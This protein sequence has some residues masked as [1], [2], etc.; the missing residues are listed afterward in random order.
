MTVEEEEGQ[1]PAAADVSRPRKRWRDTSGALRLTILVIVLF[2]TDFFWSSHTAHT[3]AQGQARIQAQ[4]I[5][6]QQQAIE[7]E[8]KAIEAGC[9]F[10]EPLV[11]LP[12]TIA[13]GATRPTK[14]GVQILAGARI[15]YAGQ[16]RPPKWPPISP[17]DPS[18]VKW[19]RAY[20][21]KL[22]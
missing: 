12:V 8:Q 19:A 4:A 16:C 9:S 5:A 21:I 18:L 15:G 22:P 2:L 13:P 1:G 3:A 6:I 20:H 14:V 11:S 17:A 7:A 10:W